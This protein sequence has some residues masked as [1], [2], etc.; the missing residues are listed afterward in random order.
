MHDIY[1]YIKKLKSRF[2]RITENKPLKHQYQNTYH[3]L[4][5]IYIFFIIL[6]V[7]FFTI[8]PQASP[9]RKVGTRKLSPVR[10]PAGGWG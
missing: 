10:D 3:V 4:N 9:R 2:P 6:T 5:E 1:F 8:A 7:S